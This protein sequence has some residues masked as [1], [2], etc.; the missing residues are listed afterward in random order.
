MVLVVGLD[1][2]VLGIEREYRTCVEIVAGMR[3]TRPR[4]GI[5]DAPVD[6]LAVLVVSAGHPGRAAARLPVV[7]LPRIMAGLARA[8]NGEGPPQLLAAIGIKRDDV[9]ANA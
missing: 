6:G 4:C 8:G 3:F 5:A 2:A 7:A 9:A 1:L